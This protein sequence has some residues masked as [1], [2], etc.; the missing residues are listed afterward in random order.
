MY[1]NNIQT[2]LFLSIL[3]KPWLV[4]DYCF[5][6]NVKTRMLKL[7][8]NDFDDMMKK[9]IGFDIILKYKLF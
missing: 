1:Q 8:V 6:P 3:S 2:N 4:N 5:K 7:L 9:N